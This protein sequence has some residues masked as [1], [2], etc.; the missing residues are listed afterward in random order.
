MSVTSTVYLSEVKA[1]AQQPKYD[2][3][4]FRVTKKQVRFYPVKGIEPQVVVSCPDKPDKYIQTYI[5]VTAGMTFSH[6]RQVIHVEN[7]RS[8]TKRLPTVA[9]KKPR[10]RLPTVIGQSK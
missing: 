6:G 3:G 10:R 9:Q 2:F 8:K 5:V 7:E 4:V 1:K